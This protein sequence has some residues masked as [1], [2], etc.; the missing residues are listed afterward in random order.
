VE[1]S[2]IF[3]L[4]FDARTNHYGSRKNALRSTIAARFSGQL[5]RQEDSL[6]VQSAFLIAARLFSFAATFAIP[7]VLVRV[8]AQAEFGVYKQLFLISGTAVPIL[9]LGFTAS[10]FYF[11]PRDGGN[12]NKFIM[13]ALRVLVTTGGLAG[14]A[15]ALFSD[16]LAAALSM[17][18][19]RDF[20]PLVGLYILIS[21]PSELVSSI[22][23]ID[24]RS[25]LAACTIGITDLLRAGAVV[26]AAAW[27]GSVDA[28]MWAA[29]GTSL[30]R[31]AWLLIYIRV[32]QVPRSATI[33]SADLGAQFRYAL[34]FA[35]TVLLDVGMVSFH[36]YYVSARVSPEAFAIYAVGILNIPLFDM[37][38]TSVGD[39]MLVRASQAY[40]AANYEELQRIWRVAVGRLAIVILP[41]WAL[42]EL[43]AP[44]LILILFG[45]AYMDAVS[46]FRVFL[47]VNLLTIIVFHAI[48]RATGD[49]PYLVKMS[50]VSLLTSVLGVILFARYSVFI[51]AVAGYS[52]GL[53]VN[54]MLGLAMVVRRIGMSWRQVL[55]WRVFAMVLLAVM[56]SAALASATLLLPHPLLR[57]PLC[58]VVFGI[59]YV[60]IAL[61][62]NLVPRAD[63]LHLVNRFLPRARTKR[64]SLA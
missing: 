58:T 30:V 33:N 42:L 56:G 21:T 32:R 1:H 36:Q 25:V 51:G 18:S 53:F 54:R 16:E 55:P 22:V 45:P 59:T 23:I 64:E 48:L 27:W 28:I 24:R 61:G 37:L 17:P 11:L 49:T 50:A 52:L 20:L 6:A 2:K 7:I 62:S 4:Y 63:M 60:S 3:V 38:V 14:L 8:L 19:A 5:R 41:L 57:I 12:G 15:L 26:G 29:I 43:L 31:A 9:T 34:P 35:V 46:I 47:S 39:V 44:D 40:K 10:L 13:Q